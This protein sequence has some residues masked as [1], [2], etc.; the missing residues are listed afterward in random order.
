MQ[1]TR[2]D[3]TDI[4]LCEPV[5]HEDDRG[6]FF[7]SFR[8]DRL[9]AFVGFD[10]NFVQENESKS[11]KGVLRGLHCQLPP[12]AQT[13]LVRVIEGSVLD[14]AVDIRHGSPTFGKHVAKLLTADN[15][16]QLLI[17]RGFAHGFIVLSDSAS[18][19]YKVDSYY[20]IN[21]ERTIL[22]NDPDLK[23]DWQLNEAEILLSGKDSASKL[24]SQCPEYFSYD[25]NYYE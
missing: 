5:V 8:H 1:F 22:F 25:E 11:S 3:I 19:S 18:I 13:K 6:Y 23:I 15:K 21:S 9:S 17:P 10:L 2:L 4:V 14:V 16:F 24:L 12:H 7:E 20:N